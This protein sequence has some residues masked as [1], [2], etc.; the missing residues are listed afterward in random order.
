MTWQGIPY[1]F[2]TEQVSSSTH[3]ALDYLPKIFLDTGDNTWSVA[4]T[5]IATILGSL[6]AGTIPAVIAW[7]TIKKNQE[8]IESDRRVQQISF[9][10]DRDAQLLISERNFNAQVISANRQ[11]WI[12]EL[13]AVISEFVANSENMVELS[14]KSSVAY[15][16]YNDC[17]ENIKGRDFS[18]TSNNQLIAFFNDYMDINKELRN[19][20]NRW[21]LLMHKASLML[22]PQE[23]IS[24][25]IISRMNKIYD[26]ALFDCRSSH[27]KKEDVN[28]FHVVRGYCN[29]LLD[30][31]KV[32]LKNEWVKTKLGK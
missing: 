12:N 23:E 17:K 6:I 11:A 8:I 30:D 31:V 7:K 22:N 16:A 10:K 27:S 18:E 15:K 25:K 3:F 24:E 9:D 2:T 1:P 19:L 4:A 26:F 28:Q 14:L 20:Q 32:C 21:G 29:V 5:M 13:R